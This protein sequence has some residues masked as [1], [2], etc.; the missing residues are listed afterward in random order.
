M[1]EYLKGH[2]SAESA[3]TVDDYPYGFRLRCKIRYWL[4]YQPKKGFRMWSQ[5]T[6]PKRAGHPW[7]KPKASTY[8]WGP[9]FL[10]IDSE[11][12]HVNS[13]CF[14]FHYLTE[15]KASD[16]LINY[17]H[18]LPVE[19]IP[20]LERFIVVKREYTR[21]LATGMEFQIAGREAVR[22]TLIASCL[23]QGVRQRILTHFLYR[24]IA[25]HTNI[26]K[27]ISSSTIGELEDYLATFGLTF[28]DFKDE[29]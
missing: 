10:G 28:K 4:E 11:N 12:G 21:L 7:N 26:N 19:F 3:F 23:K 22:R 25:E 18:L 24:S 16:L 5:T 15:S 8:T 6:N 20:E 1:I 13:H 14:D 17:G 9:S 2:T 29:I 27:L